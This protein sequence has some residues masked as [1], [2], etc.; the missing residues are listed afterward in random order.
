MGHPYRGK[1]HSPF[2][3]TG[4]KFF[5]FREK[6]VSKI[7][8]STEQCRDDICAC[9]HKVRGEYMYLHGRKYKY[10]LCPGGHKKLVTMPTPVGELKM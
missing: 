6:I 4:R 1:L 2:T 5:I 10:S 3:E 7:K 8:A 9:M